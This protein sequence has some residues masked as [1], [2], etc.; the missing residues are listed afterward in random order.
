MDNVGSVANKASEV[1]NSKLDSIVKAIDRNTRWLKNDDL[2]NIIIIGIIIFIAFFG[3]KV[4]S[5]FTT[6]FTHPLFKAAFLF[7][8]FYLTKRDMPLALMMAILFVVIM[9]TNTK[10]TGEFM[11]NV[12]GYD[13]A[14]VES[15]EEER[16][17]ENKIGDNTIS[18]DAD[19][20]DDENMI[21]QQFAVEDMRVEKCGCSNCDK[22]QQA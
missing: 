4:L 8:I 2:I 14:P 19:V 10:N 5:D 3:G 16:M 1:I 12:D 13:Y 11:T 6:I 15:S 17:A 21:A 18:A 22:S 7:V 20:V 9:M